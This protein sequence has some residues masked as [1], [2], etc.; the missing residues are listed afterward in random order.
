MK[1][2]IGFTQSDMPR[3]SSFD[4][5][6]EGEYQELL[7][8]DVDDTDATVTEIAEA[9]FEAT[10]HPSPETLTGLAGEFFHAIYDT[11]QVYVRSLSVG[12]T[13]ALPERDDRVACASYGWKCL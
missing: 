11:P 8:V 7:T 2:V 6:Q 3:Y 4:G 9:V 1:I 13:V 5:Y 12:D 10:N